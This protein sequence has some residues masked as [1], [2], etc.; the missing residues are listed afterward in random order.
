MELAL[1]AK[2]QQFVE[3]QVRGGRFATAADVVREA[4]A[5]MQA[6]ELSPH[7]EPDDEAWMAIDRAQAEFDG[8]LDRPFSDVADELRAK[9]LK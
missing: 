6:Q 1:D 5:R 9:Y 8:G 3:E 7:S 2:M 4:L